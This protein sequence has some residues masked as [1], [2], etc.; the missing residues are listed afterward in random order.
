[1]LSV[2]DWNNVGNH[3]AVHVPRRLVRSAAPRSTRVERYST[4]SSPCCHRISSRVVTS[5][6]NGAPVLGSRFVDIAV[7]VEA[8]MVAASKAVRRWGTLFSMLRSL[9]RQGGQVTANVWPNLAG[10]AR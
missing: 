6:C 3:V 2:A 5:V 1:M 7:R 8:W 9:K 10:A 4:A